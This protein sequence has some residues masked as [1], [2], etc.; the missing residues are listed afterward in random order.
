MVEHKPRSLDKI[1][2]LIRKGVDIAIELSG[3]Y[4]ALNTA[5]PSIPPP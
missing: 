2:Q 4:P 1:N 5:R 3:V